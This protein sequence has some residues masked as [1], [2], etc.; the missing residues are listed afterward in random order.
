MRSSFDVVVVGG[1]IVGCGIALELARKRLRVLVCE[2]DRV[3]GRGATTWS[4]GLLRQHHTAHCDT[5]L[6]VRS[7]PVYQQWKE[8]V[9][10]DCGYERTGFVMIVAER[11]RERLERNVA[12]VNNAGGVS[13][14]VEIEQ[15]AVKFPVMCL[16]N[17]DGAEAG[18]LVAAYEPEA[19]YVDPRAATT[20]LAAAAM[21]AGARCAEGVSVTGIQRTGDRVTGVETNIGSVSAPVVVLAAGAWS[22]RLAAGAGVE[23]PV[24]AR[25]IGLAHGNVDAS[26]GRLPIGIDDTLGTYFRPGGRDGGLYFG[27]TL[28]PAVS[29]D[30]QPAPVDPAEL[31][32]ARKTL[33]V[34]IPEV[35]HA[36]ITGARAGF[37][38]YLPDKRPAIGPYGPE[39]L[40]LCTGF[41]G[42]G[43]KVM[44]AVS[45]AVAAELADDEVS[46]LLEP[47]R[48]GRFAAGKPIES[49]DP[50]EHM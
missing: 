6:A 41:S 4:G 37:D 34:R 8:L 2:Q 24:E 27:V 5:R 14:V 43:V 16:D 42:G 1:G 17:P 49:S 13:H 30:E 50:Y 33:S 45:A 3:P 18:V 28:N 19:G 15:L 7:L 38:G 25:R 40:Y 44:P 48:P 46:S 21:S 32:L 10:G 31:D 47:Y 9:G 36:E 11:H 39:G 20:S 23:L 35:F 29:L 12:A 26:D 22:G